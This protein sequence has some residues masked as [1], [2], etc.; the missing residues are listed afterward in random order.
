[1]SK[2]NPEVG[3]Q[4]RKGTQVQKEVLQKRRMQADH[5]FKCSMNVAW[6]ETVCCFI[7]QEPGPVCMLPVYAKGP[8]E[9]Q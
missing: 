8:G 9:R 2:G 6:R 7:S 4:R 3:G 1:M 5:I